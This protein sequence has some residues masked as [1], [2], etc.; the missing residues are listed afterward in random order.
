MKNNQNNSLQ[1]IGYIFAVFAILIWS[2]NFIVARGL[3]ETIPPITIAFWR[4]FVAV[5]VFLPFALKS[6]INEWPI[7]KKYGFYLSIT[8]LL[9][10]TVFN[11]LIYIASHTTSAFNLSL[12]SITFPIFILI[13]SRIFFKEAITINKSIGILIV[14][15]G[16]VLL[17]SKGDFS[18]LLHITFSIGDLWMLLASFIFAVYSILVKS[19]PKNLRIIP[20]QFSTFVIGLIFLFPFYLWE[21]SLTPNT[22]FNL[23]SIFSILYVGIF[24]SFIAFI[25]WNKSIAKIGVI[26]S[27]VIYYLLPVFSGFFA[28]LFLDEKIT[29]VHLYSIILIVLGIVIANY[30]VNKRLK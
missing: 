29:I 26:K 1:S 15:F 2:G 24:A 9:G 4:W 7:I 10:V 3:N 17:L 6:I 18:S 22:S 21:K 11:T 27:A 19:K 28:F 16:V 25:L 5:V 20:F 23:T 8:A 14:L 12:I 30:K 13:I